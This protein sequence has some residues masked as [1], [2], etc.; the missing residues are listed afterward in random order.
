MEGDNGTLINGQRITEQELRLGEV[1]RVGNE[2]L[3]LENSFA[4]ASP[5]SNTEE[6]TGTFSVASEEDVIELVEEDGGVEVIEED[7]GLEVIEEEDG[8]EVIEEETEI[9]AV[10]PAE[11]LAEPSEDPY[12]LPHPSVDQ[13]ATLENQVLG[14]YQ[15]G[16][17]LGRGQSSLVFRAQH[18][19]TNQHVA[20]K[21]LSPDFPSSDAELQRFARALKV[22]PNLQ[23]PHLVMIHGAGKSGTYCWIARE[24]IEGESLAR[25]IQRFNKAG[26]FEW[27]C[28]CRVAI[29]LGKALCFLHQHRVTHGNITPR[30]ILIRHSDKLSKLADL[31]LNRALDGSRLQKAILGKKLMS[32]LPYLA[33]EQTDPHAPVAP[34]ADL[35]ALGTVLY[36][37]LTGQP[38]FVG[39]SPKEVLSRIREGKVVKPSKLRSGIP[40]ALEGAVLKL[41]ARRAEDRF[42][43]AAEMLAVVEPIAEEHGIKV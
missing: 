20:L 10:E 11:E 31:M 32:E 38:P 8:I 7:Y 9:V 18:L 15:I 14:H 28:A 35:Y 2:Y 5:A 41:M 30:N 6:D 27:T 39:A 12:C 26:K 4:E 25:L 16:P 33:P 37:T 43:T 23:H 29:Q 17:L 13:L 22:T 40:P 21:V 36:A 24:Y 42:P 1:L 3:R 19:K 34:L